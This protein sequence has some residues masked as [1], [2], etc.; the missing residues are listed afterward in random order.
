MR[1]I[2]VD[3][4]NEAEREMMSENPFYYISVLTT[5]YLLFVHGQESLTDPRTIES[6][7]HGIFNEKHNWAPHIFK[8]VYFAN[9]FSSP[10]CTF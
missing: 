4:G 6:G 10:S 5:Y 7:S 3:T 8:I 1:D 2:C 9:T